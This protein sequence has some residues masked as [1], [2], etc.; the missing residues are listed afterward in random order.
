VQPKPASSG[1]EIRVCELRFETPDPHNPGYSM[2]E[3][4]FYVWIPLETRLNTQNHRLTLRKNLLTGKFEV[5]RAYRR[6]FHIL[7]REGTVRSNQSLGKEEV[8][9]VGGLG[10]ALKFGDREYRKFHGRELNEKPCT[11][12][13]PR[14]DQYC[15]CSNLE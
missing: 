14:I 1:I 3:R 7:S 12:K 9:Y 2:T 5:Y 11:H 4:N 15:P 6:Y 13:S 8:I 10:G